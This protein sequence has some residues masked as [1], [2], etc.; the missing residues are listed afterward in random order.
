MHRSKI[1][2]V[3]RNFSAKELRRFGEFVHS[4]YHNKNEK[5][6]ALLNEI[7]KCA[8]GFKS[9][10]LSKEKLYEKIFPGE[11][12]REQRMLD[13]S[14]MTLELAEEFLALENIS[15]RKL[16]KHNALLTELGERKLDALFDMRLKELESLMEKNPE[17]ENIYYEEFSLAMTTMNYNF[18]KYYA[19]EK[20]Y[21]KTTDG[22][23][24]IKTLSNF[25]LYEVL[26]LYTYLVSK[27]LA[28]SQP[29]QMT[30]F[31]DLIGKLILKTGCEEP[32]V[33]LYYLALKLLLT[34][35]EKYFF[36]LRGHMIENEPEGIHEEDLKRIF[37]FMNNFCV[38]KVLKGQQEYA[39]HTL[40]ICKV[41]LKREMFL[42]NGYMSGAFF[43][44]C[45]LYS[46]STNDTEWLD[47]FFSGYSKYLPGDIR[48]STVNYSKAHLLLHRKDYHSVLRLLSHA[49]E[50]SPQ[51]KF[52]IKVLLL[53]TFYEMGDLEPIDTLLD[54]FLHQLKS[55]DIIP[56]NFRRAFTQFAEFYRR[57]LR[58]RFDPN[59]KETERLI[60]DINNLEYSHQKKWLGEQA[61]ILLSNSH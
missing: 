21:S 34:G 15:R 23:R 25:Y 20:S 55:V 49:T 42:Q 61:G 60:A 53:K 7:E 40:D 24:E 37:V 36:L 32:L 10:K 3:L 12:F 33:E 59:K 52:G 58:L 48:E 22:T 19:D 26:K 9:E 57:L 14:S 4:P 46:I 56:D 2:Q 29:P 43:L 39:K 13:L 41:F 38:G 28:F 30:G 5:V 11:K 1:L 27:Y 31:E 16:R 18:R 44:N 45:I 51:R 6:K 17:E 54:N 50:D 8:P 35:E 47:G